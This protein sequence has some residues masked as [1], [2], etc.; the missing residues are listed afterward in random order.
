[1]RVEVEICDNSISIRTIVT[2]LNITT[3]DVMWQG[4]GGVGTGQ[5]T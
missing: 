3:N 1:M 2:Y 4:G 5:F